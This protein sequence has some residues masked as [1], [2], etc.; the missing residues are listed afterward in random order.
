MA[1]YSYYTV[2][3]KG[4]RYN[5]SITHSIFADSIR[6]VEK[7]MRA[8]VAALEREGNEVTTCRIGMLMQT[9][10]GESAYQIVREGI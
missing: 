1:I 7:M 2:A 6:S 9:G 3:R 8:D 5:H 4:D 10:K